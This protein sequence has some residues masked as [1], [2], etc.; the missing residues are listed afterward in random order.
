M[1][2]RHL[3]LDDLSV[4]PD[5]LSLGPYETHLQFFVWKEMLR[6]IQLGES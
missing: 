1:I 4:V 5:T 2:F 3:A 6:F